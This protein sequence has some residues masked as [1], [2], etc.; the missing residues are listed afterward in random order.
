MQK[1][2][3]CCSLY[4]HA[5]NNCHSVASDMVLSQ[6]NALCEGKNAIFK[7]KSLV[8]HVAFMCIAILHIVRHS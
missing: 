3:M 2:L 6:L 8:L 4:E 1:R 7:Y 5:G